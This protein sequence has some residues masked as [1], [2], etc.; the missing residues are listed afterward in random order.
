[1]ELMDR[2]Q[3]FGLHT[4]NDTEHG[5]LT[6]WFYVDGT[7][8]DKCTVYKGHSD[9]SDGVY[10]DEKTVRPFVFSP[11][12]LTGVWPRPLDEISRGTYP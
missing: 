5:T 10:V 12:K 7:L 3:R 6:F 9:V 11:L 2:Y 1:M 4:R 8:C